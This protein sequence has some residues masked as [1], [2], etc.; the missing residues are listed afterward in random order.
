MFKVVAIIAIVNIFVSGN[1]SP[2]MSD[3]SPTIFKNAEA[4]Y[5][6][7]ASLTELLSPVGLNTSSLGEGS[8]GGEA[9][10]SSFPSPIDVYWKPVNSLD[11]SFGFDPGFLISDAVFLNSD[12]MSALGIQSFLETIVPECRS[13]AL[14]C[15][16]DFKLDIP[17]T[18]ADDR[19]ICGGISSK[20]N[21]SAAYAIKAV[22]DSCGI[23]P[24]VIL[25]H[26]EKEQGLV[27]STSPTSYMYRAAMGYNCADSHNLC[28]T[29]DGGFWNQIYQGSKQKLWYGNPDSEFKYFKVGEENRIRYH[30]NESCGTMSVTI[31]N[32]ATASLYYYTPY[33]PNAA[34]IRSGSGLGNE[35]SSYGNRNFF[36]FFNEWFGNSR[37]DYKFV[38]ITR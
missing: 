23:N 3:D 21:V 17:E 27:S 5:S 37:T 26:I 7:P 31:K 4:A 16:K 15:L 20:K 35:C 6:Q 38:G 34:A 19:N 9:L 22:A 18:P 30:P 24:Q 1:V 12:S 32:R 28:G 36:N 13:G 8:E 14:P 33:A 29:L 11:R 2:A 10:R 25:S